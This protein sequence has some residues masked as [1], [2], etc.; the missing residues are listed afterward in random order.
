MG[1]GRYSCCFS[2][3]RARA[4]GESLLANLENCR[5]SVRLL[6]SSLN[7][8][9]WPAL[10]ALQA[11]CASHFIVP[12]VRV[13]G[14]RPSCNNWF[15]WRASSSSACLYRATVP[16]ATIC[17]QYIPLCFSLLVPAPSAF[18]AQV[19]SKKRNKVDTGELFWHVPAP[20]GQLCAGVV[21]L[22]LSR[23]GV[24]IAPTGRNWATC[25]PSPFLRMAAGVGFSLRSLACSL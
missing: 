12:S 2:V 1:H 19:V 7:Q 18:A 16:V 17:G 23:P 20:T 24:P 21:S 22:R 9:A 25:C 15:F 6:P 11:R 13:T 8:R 14:H 4:S 5:E 3:C 10:R